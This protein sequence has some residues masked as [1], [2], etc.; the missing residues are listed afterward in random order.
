MAIE[1][2]D[3]FGGLNSDIEDRLLPNGDYR[4]ALN[5]RASKSDGSN[6]G[7]IE[8][9]KGNTLVSTFLGSGRY[10]CI[11]AY[12]NKLSNRLYYFV[13]SEIGNHSILEYNADNN[14]IQLVI[15]GAALNFQEFNV[16]PEQNIALIENLLYWTDGVNPPRKININRAKSGL[17]SGFDDTVIS[18]IKAAPVYAP[19]TS[20]ETDTTVKQNSV[21]GK[22]FQFRYAWIYEDNEQSAWSPIS[23]V[24][25]PLDEGQYRPNQFYPTELNNNI[26]IDIDLGGIDVKRVKIA[27]REGNKGDFY[28]FKDIDKTINIPLPT[29]YNFFND[30]SY[31]ALDNNGQQGMRLFDWLPL[32]ADSQALIDGNIITYGGITE[33][34]DPVEINVDIAKVTGTLPKTAPPDKANLLTNQYT[35]TGTY[36]VPLTPS[37]TA[38]DF[39]NFFNRTSGSNTI[40]GISWFFK[41]SKGSI[42]NFSG[43][44]GYNFNTLLNISRDPAGSGWES[45]DPDSIWV[46]EIHSLECLLKNDNQSL[47][48]IKPGVRVILSLNISWYN[49]QNLSPNSRVFTFQEITTA[50][51][52]ATSILNRFKTQINAITYNDN[53]V[54]LSFSC[55]VGSYSRAYGY[56]I[57]VVQSPT[58]GSILDVQV[59]ALVPPANVIGTLNLPIPCLVGTSSINIDTYSAWTTKSLKTLKMG[60]KHSIGI[61]YKDKYG[62]SG[63]TNA[64]LNKSFYVEFPTERGIS[65]G[66]ITDVVGLDLTINHKAPLWAST[67]QIVYTGNQTIEKIET[68]A[69]YNGFIQLRLKS[70]ANASGV[71]DALQGSFTNLETYKNSTSEVIELNYEFTKGDRI[72]FIK[73][74]SDNYYQSYVDVEVVSYDSTAKSIIFKK[75]NITITGDVVV[76]IYTPKKT[77][78]NEF[79]YEVGEAFPCIDGEHY[80]DINQV[81]DSSGI[82]TAPA[83]VQLRDIGDVYLKYRISPIF[84]QVEDYNFSDFYSSDSWD[85]GRTNI[86][87][88]N[89]KQIYRPSTIRFSKPFIPETNING[90]SRFDDFSFEAYDQKYGSIKLMY[91]EDKSLNIFQQLKVGQIG[92]GQNTIYGNDGNVI[93]T[94]RNETKVLSDI[95]Y[96]AG[97]YGIG[98]HP[99][100]F[101]VYGNM[102]YWVDVKRGVVL[103]LG[104]DGIT[105]ISEYGMHNYFNDTLE[106]LNTNAANTK[107]FGVYDVRFDEYII[108]L[109]SDNVKETIAFSEYKKKWVTFY[110]YMPDF[111][112]SNKSGLVS[113]KEGQLYTHNTSNNYNRFYNSQYNTIIEFLSN[114]EPSAIKFY[115]SIFVEASHVFAM[116]SATNQY[117]QKTSLLTSDFED[118]EG[119]WKAALL[120]DENTPN[121]QNALIEGDTMR[122]HSLTIRLENNDPELVKL[123]SVGLNL[124]LS[125][126][127]NR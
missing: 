88:N 114:I 25:L 4:Y 70:V 108:H 102:K 41:W 87:D 17:I 119:V 19:Q 111:M 5:I 45:G 12:D 38:N 127:T 96:Y 82:V 117:G 36:G 23:K 31:S 83:V 9:T 90:L 32:K 99:E 29:S 94:V 52:T 100:S 109:T 74:G 27:F 73:D 103:R 48:T 61:V 14:T 2:K 37:S 68:S 8:N 54:N 42:P 59:K 121:V 44:S 120:K 125:E 115:N 24:A 30:E 15:Y 77:I 55:S 60:A 89:I 49:F 107:I 28:L 35:P 76:E 39:R 84:T 97:E 71:N 18:A 124:N 43:L 53:N 92:V 26:R 7:A 3:F 113:F 56:D 101:A 47:G 6:E 81:I 110:S 62:R 104:G 34:Y 75:P 33:G 112:I 95:R 66:S 65:N 64:P 1:K 122:C 105:P 67:Y 40:A 118:S 10:K 69:G 16:I 11:G 86:I 98:N 93:G 13:W 63:L 46:S 126:L 106:S 85:K 116:S 78:S 58:Y 20:F 50:T 79:Y 22:L 72:R 21:R 123:F 57:N 91:A 80:G 51:D